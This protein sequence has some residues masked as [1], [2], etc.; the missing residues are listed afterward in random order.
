MKIAQ[1]AVVAI[2]GAALILGSTPLSVPQDLAGEQLLVQSSYTSIRYGFPIEGTIVVGAGG[3]VALRY[4][5]GA[6]YPLVFPAGTVALGGLGLIGIPGE[7]PVSLGAR[8]ESTGVLMVP[9][10]AP[11]LVP[12]PCRTSRAAVLDG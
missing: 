2:V 4:A 10:R 3:C 11:V 9:N 8:I 7:E 1:A 12:Y 5:D 6:E